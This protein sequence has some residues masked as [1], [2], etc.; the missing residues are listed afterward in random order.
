MV[1]L[2]LISKQ[3][4]QNETNKIPYDMFKLHSIRPILKNKRNTTLDIMEA[5]HN[6]SDI[7]M[8]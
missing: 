1:T 7:K 5:E 2:I 8:S 4:A 6:K 3:K